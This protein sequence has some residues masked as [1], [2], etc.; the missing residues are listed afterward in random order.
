M[1]ARFHTEFDNEVRSMKPISDE[2]RPWPVPARR[3]DMTM[4]WHSLA[5]L[6]WP[7]AAESLQASIPEPLVLDTF[8]GQAWLGV[9]PFGM[10][11]VRP[12]WAPPL[13]GVS[14]FPEINVRTYVTH[15]GKPG[16][17]FY[18]LDATNWLAVRGA[19]ALFHLP[20]YDARIQLTN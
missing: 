9:V 8:A 3:W 4:T 13:P 15:D 6:H 12:R 7:V 16:V 10:S 2:H 19:R 17:W 14:R 20:Y 5:F 1:P 18:S 11:N